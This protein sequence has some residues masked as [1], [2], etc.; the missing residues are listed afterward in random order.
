MRHLCI[1]SPFAYPVFAPEV[2]G[3]IGGAEVR[4]ALLARELVKRGRWK[5]T[6]VVRD[7]G[8][9]PVEVR[10]GVEIR[11]RRNDPAPSMPAAPARPL[12]RASIPSLRAGGLASRAL[13][14][15]LDVVHAAML[16]VRVKRSRAR[17]K[18]AAGFVGE[19]AIP[20]ERLA[21]HRDVDA[22]VYTALPGGILDPA[23]VAFFCKESGKRYVFVAS[24]DG[25]CDPRYRRRPAS[26]G[27]FGLPGYVHA[28]SIDAAAAHVAQNDAQA[29]VLRES[30]GKSPVVVRNPIDLATRVPRE[31]RGSIVLWVGKSSWIKE[32]LRFLA[33]AAD[34]PRARFRMILNPAD[35]ALHARV[36][37]AASRLGNVE[38][39]DYVPPGEVERHFA[40]A[41]LLVNTSTFEG[42][43]NTF[44]QAA[45]YG[46]P[47]VTAGVDPDGMLSRRGCGIA[48]GPR[49]LGAHVA[50]LL[51]DDAEHD[52]IA[53]RARAYV[54]A[55]HEVG[56]VVSRF[57]SVLEGMVS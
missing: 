16:P 13:A 34:L 54:A 1:V 35:A 14:G 20:R 12:T 57:E 40:E 11:H 30:F 23:E 37:A 55:E 5:V 44:L 17:A 28:F 53:A 3:P 52:A 31:G 41:R 33:I 56:A 25:D 39:L 18:D 48:G 6:L 46:V 4:A 50:R 15:A 21:L 29:A 49:D 22:D 8:Q 10:D 38:V 45:K 43:P 36:R 51:A 19:Y 26:V 2:K 24:S 9:P 27:A 47:V 42:F 7:H 32:P